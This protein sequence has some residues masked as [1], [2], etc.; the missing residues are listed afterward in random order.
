MELVANCH[1]GE[2]TVKQLG[3]NNCA[4]DGIELIQNKEYKMK[5]SSTLFVLTGL[6]PQRLK[7]VDKRK[8]P[9]YTDKKDLKESHEIQNGDIDSTKGDMKEKKDRN[10]SSESDKKKHGDKSKSKE[11]DSKK[12]KGGDKK[13]SCGS[14]KEHSSKSVTENSKNESKIGT[15]RSSSLGDEVMF[16]K[17]KLSN[18]DDKGKRNNSD[19]SKG[20]KKSVKFCDNVDKATSNSMG[21]DDDDHLNDVASKLKAM[22]EC[23]KKAKSP[24]KVN[25]EKIK[26]AAEEGNSESVASGSPVTKSYWE[27]VESLYVYRSKGLLGKNKVNYIYDKVVFR[28]PYR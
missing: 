27:N 12:W 26:T 1:T 15:K 3:A 7:I 24:E 4:L 10:N 18:S 13:H 9:G 28:M 6:Y 5:P 17:P 8:T 2:V 25:S 16:K 23:A 20:D 14:D 19:K 21:D 22:K 11:K